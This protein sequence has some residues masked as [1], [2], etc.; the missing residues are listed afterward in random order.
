MGNVL[1]VTH[2]MFE[3]ELIKNALANFAEHYEIAAYRSLLFIS[4]QARKNGHLPLQTSLNE[5]ARM[6]DGS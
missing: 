1:A 4:E 6:A 3:D 5:E 2:S